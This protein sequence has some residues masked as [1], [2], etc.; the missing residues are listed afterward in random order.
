M[1]IDVSIDYLMFRFGQSRVEIMADMFKNFGQA[2][3]EIVEDII[4]DFWT[5]Q[6]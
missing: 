5:S 1:S 3:V 6:S 4:Q 2:R